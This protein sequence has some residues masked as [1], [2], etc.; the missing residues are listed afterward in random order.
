LF[1]ILAKKSLFLFF[2]FFLGGEAAASF[3]LVKTLLQ[4]IQKYVWSECA[5]NLNQICVRFAFEPR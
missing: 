1:S 5:T 4:S 2:I 3:C